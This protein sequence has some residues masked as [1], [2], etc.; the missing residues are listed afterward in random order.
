MIWLTVWSVATCDDVCRG[1]A[2]PEHAMTRP[3]LPLKAGAIIFTLLW[4]AWMMWWGGSFSSASVVILALCGA[5][6][7]YLWYRAMRW[8]FERMG[9]LPRKDDSSRAS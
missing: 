3:L 2:N 4:T 8:Q 7:G 1:F 9:M 6:V 5:A